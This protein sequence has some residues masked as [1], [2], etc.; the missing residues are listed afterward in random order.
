MREAWITGI[1]LVTALG[2][3]RETTWRRLLAGETGI[4]PL[5][6]FDTAGYR[7]HIAAQVDDVAL[8]LAGLP[9]S[10]GRHITPGQPFRAGR[11]R[12]GAGRRRPAHRRRSARRGRWCSGGGAAGLFEA[13]GFVARRLRGGPRTR[14]LGE[15]V[16]VP[17]DS[18]TDRV[19]QCFALTGPRIT[20]T[21]A[22]SSS[23]DRGRDRRRD[24]PRRRG[25]GRPRRR[26][27]CASAASPTRASTR[28]TPSTPSRRSRSTA[29]ARACHSA[30]GRRVL[31][32][33]EA[34]HAR[35]R[36]ARPYAR[37]LG[38]GVTNDAFH[39]TQPEPSG[40]AWERT[41]RA[42]LADAGVADSEVDYINAPRHRHRAERRG[43]VRRLP[44]RVRRAA[45]AP[46][47][48]PR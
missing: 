40:A 7:T 14:G 21:T 34:E 18:P 25:R 27:R 35:R 1:G 15:L 36:G 6:L 13:E 2:P 47:R 28:C 26:L 33:E 17:Q 46:C 9:R 39:M 32:V 42:A 3:D 4:R 29:A 11:R 10:P 48:S 16:E 20:V 12:R 43:R 5:T 30:R 8:A 37:V 38:Y 31:V 24:G 44:P 19:A 23:T 41:V 45:R 22:C